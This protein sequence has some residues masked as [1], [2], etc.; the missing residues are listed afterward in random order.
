[1][2]YGSCFSLNSEHYFSG[3][4]S[5]NQMIMTIGDTA[6]GGSKGDHTFRKKCFQSRHSWHLSTGQECSI[7]LLVR[8][9]IIL[10]EQHNM[11]NELDILQLV[12]DP[13]VTA[14]LV[15]KEAR[16]ASRKLPLHSLKGEMALENQSLSK[17]SLLGSIQVCL[18]TLKSRKTFYESQPFYCNRKISI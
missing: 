15:A 12:I 18:L 5:S 13:G 9:L 14:K 7:K 10:P 2:V 8:Q 16:I 4:P 1:M 17:L 11:D 3:S 6:Q